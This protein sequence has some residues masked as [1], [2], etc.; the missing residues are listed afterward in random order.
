MQI[1]WDK[2]R[3]LLPV[4]AYEYETTGETVDNVDFWYPHHAANKGKEPPPGWTGVDYDESFDNLVKAIMKYCKL[5]PGEKAAWYDG[6]TGTFSNSWPFVMDGTMLDA[7]EHA[8]TQPGWQLI[9]Y[10]S[11]TQ[12]SFQFCDMMKI[13]STTKEDR[14]RK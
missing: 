5:Q 7:I 8:K 3:E 14:K 11:L 4:Y 12:E 13:V 10:R 9:V 2:V 1:D 6:N